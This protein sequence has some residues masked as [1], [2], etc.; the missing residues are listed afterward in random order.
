MRQR[1]AGEKQINPMPH[2]RNDIY[3]THDSAD[4]W[5]RQELFR[6]DEDGKPEA[7]AGVPPD[8]YSETGQL[9]GYPLYRWD[10]MERGGF[11]W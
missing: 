5:S 4:A 3:V 1:G 10:E 2:C 8:A 11:S 9:W 7:V 6:F